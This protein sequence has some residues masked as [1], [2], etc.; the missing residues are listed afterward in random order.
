MTN[1]SINLTGLNINDD[2]INNQSRMTPEYMEAMGFKAENIENIEK[3]KEINTSFTGAFDEP[4]TSKNGFFENLSDTADAGIVSWLKV[5]G[6]NITSENRAI[7]YQ[8]MKEMFNGKIINDVKTLGLNEISE[9]K[10]NTE[11]KYANVKQHAGYAAEV[12]STTKENLVSELEGKG[13]KTIRT[14]DLAHE[15]DNKGYTVNDQYVDKVRMDPDGNII[16]RIQTKFVGKNA[17][18]CLKRLASKDFEKYLDPNKV[19]KLEIPSDFYDDVKNSLLPEKIN[20]LE[21]QVTKLKELGK[22]DELI[23][24][25]AELDKYKRIDTM[26][27]K[28]MV[29]N[30]EAQAA[31][32]HPKIYKAQTMAKQLV[33]AG[34]EGGLNAAKYAAGLTFA[35]STVDNIGQVCE[36]EIEI[37][38]AVVNIIED[39]G[40]SAVL[41]YGTGFVTSSVQTA[42]SASSKALIQKAGNSCLPAAAVSFAVESYDDVASYIKGD[43]DAYELADNLGENGAKVA[44]GIVGADLGTKAGAAIG[45][46]ICPGAGTAIGAAVGGVAGGIVGGMVGA[47]VAAEAYN[48]ATDYIAEHSDELKA[49]AETG[50]DAV[51]QKADELAD[52]AQKCANDVI[53]NVAISAPE[54]VAD[55]KAAFA[56][57]SASIK[58]PFTLGQ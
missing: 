23:K 42:M 18:E 8:T 50:M 4:V 51:T 55:V 41:G 14:D 49:M 46:A 43:I 33:D 5:S 21:E 30:Q 35:I 17:N 36:G 13:I 10:I 34:N 2:E 28:S 9:W 53:T 25:Q 20:S 52:L 24:K 44:G 48:A 1:E 3:I 54:A 26:L 57:F 56:D 22:N 31:V 37:D 19:D 16:E 32:V 27:E 39:T 45:T 7:A 40:M 11:N 38:E 15:V 6:V 47:T 12:I 58:L 29:S